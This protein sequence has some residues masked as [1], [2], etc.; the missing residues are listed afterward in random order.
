MARRRARS[1][2]TEDKAPALA[3]EVRDLDRQLAV[4]RAD[5]ERVVA[6]LERQEKRGAVIESALGFSPRSKPGEKGAIGA[7]NAAVLKLEEYLL[8]TSERID[9]ILDALKQHREFLV[10]LDTKVLR[11]E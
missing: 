8:R 6:R 9:T 7:I 11:G 10:D 3:R 5:L 1:A 4:L 2:S